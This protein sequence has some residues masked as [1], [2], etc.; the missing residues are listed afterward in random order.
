MFGLTASQLLARGTWTALGAVGIAACSPSIEFTCMAAVCTAFYVVVSL[1][2]AHSLRGQ[3][4]AVEGTPYPAWSFFQGLFHNG[5]VSLF[6][7]F[8]IVVVRSC[9]GELHGKNLQT[10][11]FS[12]WGEYAADGSVL[13]A[14][15]I[16]MLVWSLT[17]AH[18]MKDA[19]LLDVRATLPDAGFVIHHATTVVGAMFCLHVPV[20][21]GLVTLNALNAYLG[22]AMYTIPDI[23]EFL[24]PER[25]RAVRA[26]R[27]AYYFAMTAS[28][29][30]GVIIGRE[31]DRLAQGRME[32]AEV[33]QY[34]LV[35]LV[36][37]R[38]MP[39]ILGIRCECFG[40][41]LTSAKK[42][43]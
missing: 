19:V 38:Q 40:A 29:V 23:I 26:A 20:G 14:E 27:C 16:D 2:F 15:R 6:L 1:A 43:A 9:D 30:L 28:N 36:M 3:T 10:W 17:I 22:S 41:G 18:E 11:L 5:G 33:Y 39:V 7:F 34:L 25:R 4:I 12:P 21:K 37:V 13:L 31:F 8:L 24:W 42:S 32:H 35:M